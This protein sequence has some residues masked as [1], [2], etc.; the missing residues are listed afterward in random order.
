VLPDLREAAGRAAFEAAIA[1]AES[2]TEPDPVRRAA[3]IRLMLA[4]ELATAALGQAELRARAGDK[5]G[6]QAASLYFTSDG[7]EQSTRRELADHRARR[8]AAAGV[9]SVLDLCCGIGADALGFGRV[10]LAVA[11]V[12]R[13]PATAAIAEANLLG[14]IPPAVVEVGD[15]EASGWRG[16]ESVFLDPARRSDRGRTFDPRA[17]SPPFE[18]TLQVLAESRLAAAKLSPGL[19]HELIP[20]EIEAEWVS[21]RGGVKEA[22]LWSAGFRDSGVAGETVSRRATVLPAGVQLTDADS[23]EAALRP[24]GAYLLEPDGAVIRAGLVQQAAAALGAARIDEHLAYLTAAEPA[25]SA[26]A[27]SFRVLDV[28]PYSVKRIKAELRQREIGIVEIKKRGVDVDPA[29]LRR[30]LK[31]SGPNSL[32]LLLA[33]VG[34]Q[35]LAVLA[36]PVPAAN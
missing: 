19:R 5:F 22:V 10:G 4:P 35:H 27:R 16:A 3:Q 7:L 32:T 21:F 2:V 25:S 1:V 12:E 18:F 24:I 31:P 23:A 14:L 20:A 33:R 13:D 15:A 6:P 26:L 28:V 8:F 30:A 34:E 9:R 36:E 29:A 11:A 17:F